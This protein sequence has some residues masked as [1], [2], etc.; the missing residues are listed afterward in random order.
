M[1]F[2]NS[3]YL[4]DNHDGEINDGWWLIEIDGLTSI[5]EVLGSPVGAY[6]LRMGG[7]PLNANLRK[8]KCSAKC[9]HIHRACN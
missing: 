5:R 1:T 2:E 6:A 8:L 9:F 3:V 4:V 7:H